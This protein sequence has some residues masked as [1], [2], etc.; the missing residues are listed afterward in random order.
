MGTRQPFLFASGNEFRVR[1]GIGVIEAVVGVAVLVTVS[2]GVFVVA[3][4]AILAERSAALDR[5]AAAV[6]REALE[7]ARFERDADWATFAARPLN[8]A[9]YPTYS[10][11]S[12]SLSTVDP[13]AVDGVF[14]RTVTLFSV[15]RDGSGNIAVSGNPD[16]SARRAVASVSWNDAFGV[17]RTFTIDAYLMDVRP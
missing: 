2:V 7:V 14:T 1:S 4:S 16:N 13:G 11:A 10:G 9:L 12:A 15:S 8:T 17:S 3:R 6:A 5:R